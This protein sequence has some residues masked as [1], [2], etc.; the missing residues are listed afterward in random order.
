MEAV[1]DYNQTPFSGRIIKEFIQYDGSLDY[2]KDN[3]N[4]VTITIKYCNWSEGNLEG[5]PHLAGPNCTPRFMFDVGYEVCSDFPELV[6]PPSPSGSESPNSGTTSTSSGGSNNNNT[7]VII[8]NVPKIESILDIDGV[9]LQMND[10]LNRIENLNI[11]LELIN[12]FN[13]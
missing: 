1:E 13:E 5:T 4:C 9:S 10:W 12:I 2:L 3:G 6:D 11:K 8:P 7:P